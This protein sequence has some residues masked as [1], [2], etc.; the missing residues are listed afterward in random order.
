M[1]VRRRVTDALD[2]VR[3]SFWVWPA[4]MGSI[5]FGLSILM[6]WID[7][8]TTMGHTLHIVSSVEAA[9]AI[10]TVI[11]SSMITVAGVVYS[12][13]MVTLSLAAS[14]FGSRLLRA[15]MEDRVTQISLGTIVS[16]SMYSFLALRTV[17]PQWEP[18]HCTVT[19]GLVFGITGLATL[20]YFTHHVSRSIQAPNVVRAVAHDMHRSLDTMFPEDLGEATEDSWRSEHVE[21]SGPFAAVTSKVEGYMQGIDDNLMMHLATKHDLEIELCSRPGDYIVPGMPLARVRP[22][23]TTDKVCEKL[24]ECFDAGTTRTPRQDI[25]A[26]LEELLAVTLRAIS[27]AMNANFTA[28][29]AIDRLGGVLRKLVG[30]R[31]PSPYRR[32]DAGKLRVIAVP[33]MFGEIV[34]KTLEPIREYSRESTMVTLRLLSMMQIVAGG[35]RR[36]RD[37]DALHDMVERI[38]AGFTSPDTYCTERVDQACDDVARALG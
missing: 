23:G 30:R 16:A 10:L 8:N 6:P 31:I 35:A 13:T 20:V 24:C 2:W 9:R 37:K 34:N 3:G 25:V 26:P 33:F 32:D 29:A 12:I 4:V 36:Q 22:S 5:G 27:P 17:G 19:A 18:P 7:N 38:R 28:V 11:G 1:R 21:P 14:Q 15:L